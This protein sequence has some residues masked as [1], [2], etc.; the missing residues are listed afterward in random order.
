M[1]KITAWDPSALPCHIAA[2]VPRGDQP[3]DFDRTACSPRS[4]SKTA[5]TNAVDFALAA[6]DEALSMAAWRPESAQERQMTG[7]AIGG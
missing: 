7:V 1:S 5:L 2:S 6:S 3:L 4:L